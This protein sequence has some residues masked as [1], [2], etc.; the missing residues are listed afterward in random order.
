MG[1]RQIINLELLGVLG[2]Q[3]ATRFIQTELLN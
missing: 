2:I 1:D 3:C